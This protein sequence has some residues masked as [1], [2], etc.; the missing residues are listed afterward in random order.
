M[1]SLKTSSVHRH[2][3][4]THY[5]NNYITHTSKHYIKQVTKLTPL[6]GSYTGLLIALLVFLP[7]D[8]AKVLLLH[9]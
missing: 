5:I 2:I 6:V 8:L 9:N 4:N 1:M 7:V 3:T